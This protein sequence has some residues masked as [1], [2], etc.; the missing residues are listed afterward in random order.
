LKSISLKKNI[1]TSYVSQAYVVIVGILVLPFYIV[2]MGAEAY[3]LVGFFTM[4]QA[5]F[6]LLDLGLTP[7]I[8]RETARFRAGMHSELI[9][10]QLYRT[11]NVIFLG[12]A[13]IGG[14]IL[15]ILSGLIAERWLNVEYLLA[16]EVIFA[17]QVMAVS[18]ALRWMTG[19]YRGVVSGSEQ[20]AWL[21]GF[22]ALIVTLRFLLVFPVMWQYGSTPMVFFSYQLVVALIEFGG[23]WLKANQFRPKLNAGQKNQLI[24]SIKPIKPYLGFA[25]S[26]ALT[27]G[28]WVIVTQ[29]DKL[30]MSTLLSLENYGYF[31]L[32]VLVASGIMMLSGPIS[33]SIMPRMVKLEAEG[34]REELI[35][36][37]R[38]ATQFVTVVAG[39]SSI[40]MVVFAEPI[41]YVW[42]GDVIMVAKVAPVLQF[43]AMGFGLIAVGAF[44]YYLQY[45]LGKLNL[46]II[47]SMLFALI[48]L[49]T[50]WFA[51]QKYGMVG[52]AYAWII[53]NLAYFIFWTAFVHHTYV[54]ELHFKW[55][56]NDIAK[57]LI[58]PVSS[59]LLLKEIFI[60]TSRVLMLVELGFIGI[61][62]FLLATISSRS[63]RES[64]ATIMRFK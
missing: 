63:T 3:G 2:E 44:P 5:I 27:S 33:V 42:T 43:Y 56:I 37:Y 38:K 13:L 20:I 62:V 12:I 7:T 39:S 57:L 8:G 23:L 51:T 29:M 49:P 34:K 15:F 28:L 9:F 50:L 17:L 21:S 41:L 30:I 19:L 64:L 55:L 53:V 58:L 16:T 54:P 24:W 11:L 6:G 31:T 22:N 46:H 35:K 45:A 10:S 18:V 4:L 60:E 32:A 25:L 59:A 48:L 26:V 47:G 1:I 40:M 36:V 14:G 61:L 52:A